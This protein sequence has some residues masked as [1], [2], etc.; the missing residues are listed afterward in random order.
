MRLFVALDIDESIRDRIV[1]FLGEGVRGVCAGG[2]LGRGR[3]RCMSRVKVHW[4]SGLKLVGRESSKLWQPLQAAAFEVKVRGYG[5]FPGG[6]SAACL[7]GW[8]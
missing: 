7:L 3:N 4:R 2:A 1:R 6:A 8:N 5:F